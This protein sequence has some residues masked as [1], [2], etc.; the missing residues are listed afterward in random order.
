[1]TCAMDCLGTA[2]ERPCIFGNGAPMRL[3]ECR[4]GESSLLPDPNPRPCGPNPNPPP[5]HW[6]RRRYAR[7][8]IHTRRCTARWAALA[9]RYGNMQIGRDFATVSRLFGEGEICR[10]GAVERPGVACGLFARSSSLL[11]GCGHRLARLRL[12][13]PWWRRR[14]WSIQSLSCTC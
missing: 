10:C 2:V 7:G 12:R 8:G 14:I 1:M 13:L 11:G 4:C 3:T 5:D 9:R 6:I